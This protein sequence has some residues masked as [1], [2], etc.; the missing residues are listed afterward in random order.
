[1]VGFWHQHNR[2]ESRGGEA[3]D[4]CGACGHSKVG[5]PVVNGDQFLLAMSLDSTFNDGPMKGKRM[6]MLEHAMYTVKIGRSRRRR[7]FARWG[8]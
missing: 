6:D 4:V 7:S 2:E 8:G 3:A 1:M 5:K